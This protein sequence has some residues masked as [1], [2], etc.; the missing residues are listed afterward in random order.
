MTY[1]EA[2][3]PLTPGELPLRNLH[4]ADAS[5]A[6]EKRERFLTSI[7]YLASRIREPDPRIA[8]SLRAKTTFSQGGSPSRQL[9][10]Q[11]INLIRPDIP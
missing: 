2:G 1:F 10:I 7:N 11:P 6:D 8:E 3:V 9:Y 5:T 4:G